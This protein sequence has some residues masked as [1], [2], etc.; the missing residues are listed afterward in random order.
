MLM[1]S[2]RSRAAYQTGCAQVRIEAK[3]AMPL[4]LHFWDETPDLA[5]T[6]T[7]GNSSL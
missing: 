1:A 4:V 6:L 7:P 3:D 2:K 5:I